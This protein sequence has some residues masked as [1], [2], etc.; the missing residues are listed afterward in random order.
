MK[1]QS[2]PPTHSCADAC[3]MV[4]LCVLPRNHPV[5]LAQGT[6]VT[7]MQHLM[8]CDSYGNV[9]VIGVRKLIVAFQT[10]NFVPSRLLAAV[11]QAKSGIAGEKLQ[12]ILISLQICSSNSAPPCAPVNIHTQ[13]TKAMLR[14]DH[15]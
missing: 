9:F 3:R 4:A 11:S 6:H 2:L 14:S 13:A 1:F 8:P 15:V 7:V 5:L 12:F 10:E